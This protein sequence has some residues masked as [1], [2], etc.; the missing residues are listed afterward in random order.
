MALEHRKKCPQSTQTVFYP[1]ECV[2]VNYSMARCNL[3]DKFC[4]LETKDY[5]PYYEDWLFEQKQ[6]EL[7][8]G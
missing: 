3:N 6:E 1:L 8:R 2:L 4:L 7:D 5:C